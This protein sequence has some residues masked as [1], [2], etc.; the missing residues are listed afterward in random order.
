ME[1]AIENRI[2]NDNTENL[3]GAEFGKGGGELI[4]KRGGDTD[5]GELGVGE[6]TG[7][8]MGVGAGVGAGD[9]DWTPI[10]IWRVMPARQWPGM[11]LMKKRV[12]RFPS[13][14]LLLPSVYSVIGATVVHVL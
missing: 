10:W 5:G 4:C 1:V 8:G 14:T 3:G 2:A 13:S 7:A 12:V 6:D 9:G 11:P